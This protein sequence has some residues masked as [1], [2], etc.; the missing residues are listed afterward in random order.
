MNKNYL[1]IIFH[2][3]NAYCSS[4]VRWALRFGCAVVTVGVGTSLVRASQQ[5]K[6]WYTPNHGTM[7]FKST[8]KHIYRVI[9]RFK[10]KKNPF[11]ED[12]PCHSTWKRCKHSGHFSRFRNIIGNFCIKYKTKMLCNYVINILNLND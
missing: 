10:I 9:R 5:W 1:R 6:H 11:R 7:A 12:F 4:N 3:C 2:V 8:L